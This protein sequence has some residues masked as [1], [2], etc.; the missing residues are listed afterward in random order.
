ME[1]QKID[2]RIILFFQKIS[3]PFARISLFL[4]FFWFGFLKLLGL[5][6]AAPLVSDLLQTTLPGVA[7]AEFMIFLGLWEISIGL[8]FILP[9]FTRVVMPLL[10]IHLATTLLPLVFLPEVAWQGFLAPTLAGQYIIKNILII[11]LAIGIAA[12]LT[13]MKKNFKDL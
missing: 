3:V 4:V 11:A 6:S 13:P 1:M 8:L 2:E 12:H 9:K 7:E 5:S 10:L